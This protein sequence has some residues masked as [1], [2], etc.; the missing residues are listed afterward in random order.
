MTA[1]QGSGRSTDQT[2]A[3]SE[4]APGSAHSPAVAATDTQEIAPL[5]G[6][7]TTAPAD[8]RA[9]EA[10]IE[11]T[12]EQLGETVQ[13]LAARA[14]VKS[15]A[16]AKAAEVSERVK[17]ATAQ[18]RGN[19]GARARSVRSQAAS[20]TGAARQQVTN[21]ARGAGERR[22]PLTVAAAGVLAIGCAAFNE[23]NR[24]RH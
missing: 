18:V 8:V 3:D 4:A 13:E 12:R 1:G 16:R 2:G 6:S 14:D 9:L 10:E 11:R 22:V 17:G 24:R 23:W 5:T 7:V 21:V 15:R 19:A 20:A